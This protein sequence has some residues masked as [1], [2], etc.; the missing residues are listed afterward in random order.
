MD[1]TFPRFGYA[2]TFTPARTRKK[3]KNRRD[4][5]LPP[6]AL[7]FERTMGEL[8]EGDWVQECKQHLRSSLNHVSSINPDVLCL[9]LGSPSVSRDSRAQLAFLL[10]ICDDLCIGRDQI[11]VYDPVFTE[12]DSELLATLQVKRLADNRHASYGIQVPTIVF[13][14]HCDL[15]LYENLLR[16]NWS[17]EALPNIVLIA[18]RLSDYSES[19]P[20]RQFSTEYPCVWRLTPYLTSRPIPSCRAYPKAFNSTSIQI[21]RPEDLVG[22][23]DIWWELPNSVHAEQ[24]GNDPSSDG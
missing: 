2:D 14:P 7:L 4:R 15:Q 16:E 22:T 23:K 11:S 13:M 10:A 8:A 3:R 1:Q 6:P 18:N 9:G 24:P 5:E 19:S 20:S 12:Q 21:T 17:R